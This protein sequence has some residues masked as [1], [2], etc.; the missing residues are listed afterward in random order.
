MGSGGLVLN[1]RHYGQ[2]LRDHLVHL[3]ESPT[4]ELGRLGR[5]AVYQIRLWRFC[6][7][8]LVQDRLMTEAGDI[9]FKTLL[10]LIPAL[11]IFLLV[12][13]FFSRGPEIGRQVQ[14]A[15]FQALNITDIHLKV[16][17]EEVDLVQKVGAMVEAVRE[18]MNR[19]A[20]VGLIVL[21]LLAVEVL[22]TVE[23]AMN[24]IWQIRA[25]RPWWKRLA[26]H[27]GVL[28]LAPCAAALAVYGYNQVYELY[29]VSE[30][31]LEGGRWAVGLLATWFVFY[32]F[33]KLLPNTHVRSRAALA[34]AIVAGAL[35]HVL[36]RTVFGYYLVHAVGY[37]QIYGTLAVV[38]LFFV[39]VWVSWAIVLFGCELASVVQNFADLS[40]AEALDRERRRGGSPAPDFVA[41]MALV[42][43]ARRDGEGRG[44]TPLR[45]LVEATGVDRATLEELLGAW[46]PPTWWSGPRRAST[47]RKT[48]RP[49][50][51][52]PTPAAL[53]WPTSCRPSGPACP[54]RSTPPT[55]AAPG[56]PRRLRAAPG[57]VRR[58]GRPRDRGRT[59]P[60]GREDCG[61]RIVNCGL[62]Q[63][64]HG[65]SLL[66]LNPRSSIFN[67]PRFLQPLSRGRRRFM[68][69]VTAR[70]GRK[71]GGLWTS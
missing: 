11:V 6:G 46:R 33:Y 30:P 50:C 34:G 47:A 14:D 17:G 45:V 1:L 55:C 27:L 52:P 2:R 40:R 35:W 3:L 39:W 48:R 24:R 56:G 32:V 19:A 68:M 4:D 54:C 7:R 44:P 59:G 62:R 42:A 69:T 41:L 12:I 21:V 49:S 43:A 63:T 25:R 8:H 58:P 70:I 31:W 13:N 16:D 22:A 53:P 23:T 38:P 65:K 28:V 18:R 10:G 51:P 5:I 20:W 9:T 36:A 26:L 67:A 29:T 15:I 61:L 64:E 57:R 66:I 60:G 37:R 71:G